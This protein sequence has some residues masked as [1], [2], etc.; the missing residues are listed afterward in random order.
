MTELVIKSDHPEAVR[1]ELQAALDGQRRIFQEIIKRTQE[2]LAAF[3]EKYG[4][5][6]PDLL[7]RASH[8]SFDDSNLE[9]IEWIG[10]A[11]L[12]ERLRA[13]LALLDDIKI[14]T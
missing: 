10:E 1:T 4:L 12:L 8:P 3:E 11:R 13:E 2:H 9:H 7:K 14:C 6:T 5:T